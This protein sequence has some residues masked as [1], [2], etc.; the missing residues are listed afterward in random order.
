MGALRRLRYRCLH[1]CLQLYFL[2][3][4]PAGSVMFPVHRKEFRVSLTYQARTETEKRRLRGAY[5][6]SA[7][8]SEPLDTRKDV[9]P[10]I[11]AAPTTRSAPRGNV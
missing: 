10:T 8:R 9:R 2:V 3:L 7:G 4:R 6:G 1:C 5:T 11:L